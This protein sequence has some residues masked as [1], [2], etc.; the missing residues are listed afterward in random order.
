MLRVSIRSN[1]LL[2]VL[3]TLTL[4]GNLGRVCAFA[5]GNALKSVRPMEPIA[6]PINEAA[7]VLRFFHF[8]SAQSL[9]SC[10]TSVF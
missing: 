2:I 9:G 5:I 3:T 8:A 10:E 4:C 6:V 7:R 1:T